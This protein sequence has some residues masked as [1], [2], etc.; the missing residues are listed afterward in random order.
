MIQVNN[1]IAL[2]FFEQNIELERNQM[3]D[4][5][6]PMKALKELESSMSILV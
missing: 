6:I 3:R 2:T 5:N 4:L 1:V